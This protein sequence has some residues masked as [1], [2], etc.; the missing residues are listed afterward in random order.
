M[1]TE[2]N[3]LPLRKELLS[4]LNALDYQAMTPVQEQALPV[5]LAGDDV[6]AMAITGSGKTAAFALG[7]LNQL[8]AQ[9]YRTQALVLTPTRELAE[10]VANEIRRLA[11]AIPNVKVLCLSG[12]R[13]MGPQLA[14]L[15]RSPHI[16][17]GTPGRILKHLEKRSLRLDS[18]RT[19]VLDEA[20]RMLDMGFYDDMVA[21]IAN[22]P[23]TRQTLLFSATFP[24]SIRQVSRNVQTRP[25]EL[26]IESSGGGPDIDQVF[27]PVEDAE[28]AE[29]LVRIIARY[30]PPSSLVFC[31]T[32]QQCQQLVN[33]LRQHGF[34]AL[35]LHGD[36][37][38]HQRDQVLARFA[39]Q[40][41]SILVATD[42][43]ARGLDVKELAAVINFELA[44]DPEVH[45]HRIGRT[46]RAGSRGLAVSLFS[47]RERRQLR[48][49]EDSQ[50]FHVTLGNI[51]ELTDKPGF[52]LYPPM[53]TLMVNSGRKDKLRAGDLLGALTAKGGLSGA[54]VGK[55]TL[56]D[57]VA[58][59]AVDRQAADTAL[60]MLVEGGV[61]GRK[62]Q[63][64]KLP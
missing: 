36:L 54:Q 10:Q 26:R 56:F 9:E 51:V 12:G 60:K 45:I 13:P 53:V 11:S 55:I 6:I 41:S 8:D 1:K 42:M 37:E 25:V 64:R 49:I 50:G 35:A 39:G 24:D 7:V 63:A 58:Y 48:A 31:N 21:I 33:T 28:R 38:Q 62:I 14:S 30:R 18:V 59:V 20:D 22:L 47:D 34:H 44:R 46:G 2:F 23:V 43:A 29:M 5:V 40:S 61:K 15:Q 19:L 17:V 57:T 16:V 32:R 27:Y 4:S 52:T 3:A